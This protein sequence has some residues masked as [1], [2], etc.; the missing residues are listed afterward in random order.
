M[1]ST[2]EWF[3]ATTYRLRC[4]GLTIFLDT[5]LDRPSLMPKYMS[6]DD[7]HEADYVFI[8]HPHFDH[9]P[10]ADRIA[11]KTGAIVIANPEAINVLRSAGVPDSQLMPV[12]GGERIPL[13]PSHIRTLAQEGQIKVAPVPPGF[14]IQPDLSYAAA[15][16]HVWPSLHCL[17]AG[18]PAS[19]PE[20]QDSGQEWRGAASPFACTLDITNGMK[21]RLLAMSSHLPASGADSKLVSFAEYV[22]DQ[23][24][25][26]MSHC[27]G[28]QLI[29]NFLAGGK[30]MLWMAHLGGYEGVL[31]AMEPKPDTVIM[32][33]AGRAN[34]NGRPF[35]GSAAQFARDVLR[36]LGEP[37]RV[38]WCLHD[39]NLLKPW[40]VNT[41]PATDL[42]E[43]DTKSRV[44]DMEHAKLYR[45][46][47]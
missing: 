19:M 35:D 43:K 15:S 36:W 5:W 9:L 32:A 33:I 11:L 38:I 28:G 46:F 10:G 22:D 30:A 23:Q 26:R 25:N 34:L 17:L 39:E 18:N 40:F 45:T 12:T 24:R 3:G 13:F 4:K 7:V 16:V 8:S 29:F 41:R 2:I 42:V 27:D 37:A 47:G 44:L 14:P 20:I 1:D 21:Y 31:R 6:T